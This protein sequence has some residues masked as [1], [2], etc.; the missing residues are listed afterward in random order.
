MF[1]IKSAIVVKKV[2]NTEFHSTTKGTTTATTTY[3]D[4]CGTQ[5]S[6]AVFRHEVQNNLTTEAEKGSSKYN[7]DILSVL[8][9]MMQDDLKQFFTSKALFTRDILAHNIAIKRYCDI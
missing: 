2:C 7:F 3:Q 4:C 9:V 5:Q 1:Q 6:A 8:Q